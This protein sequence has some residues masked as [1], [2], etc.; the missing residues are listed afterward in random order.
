MAKYI[1]KRILSSLIVIFGIITVT[2]LIAR[3]IPSNAAAKWVGSRA[4]VEQIAAAEIELGLDKPLPVQFW[5][6]LKQLLE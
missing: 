1:F 4:T 2:F 3:V 6:Y 5:T